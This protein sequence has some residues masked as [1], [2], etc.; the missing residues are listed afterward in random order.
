MT[1]GAWFCGVNDTR[2]LIPRCHWHQEL[3][4]AV[5]M[6]PGAWFRSVNDTRSLIPR[7][8]WHQE[9]DSAVPMTPGAWFHGVTVPTVSNMNHLCDF[10]HKK[11]TKTRWKWRLC[12]VYEPVSPNRDVNNIKTETDLNSDRLSFS[13][14]NNSLK[15]QC[16]EIFGIFFH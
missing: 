15:R 13:I 8:Q 3:D 1:P 7:G 16:H 2:S 4:S 5:S 10:C 12:R 14:S 11:L 9:L 6:T